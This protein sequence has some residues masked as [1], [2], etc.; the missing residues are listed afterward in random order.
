MGSWSFRLWFLGLEVDPQVLENPILEIFLNR[1]I[2]QQT[3]ALQKATLRHDA[4]LLREQD[5][6]V[7]RSDEIR[8]QDPCGPSGQSVPVGNVEGLRDIAHLLHTR[9]IVGGLLIRRVDLF[10]TELLQA[11]TLR[12]S[13]WYQAKSRVDL[14]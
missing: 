3:R 7:A 5:A 10:A 6:L 14:R 12:L 11:P 13:A 8:G 2:A 1:P 9:L 4:Y